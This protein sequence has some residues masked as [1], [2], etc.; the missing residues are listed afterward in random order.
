MGEPK[1]Y[2]DFYMVDGFIV[3]REIVVEDY[4][5]KPDL[6]R[7]VLVETEYEEVAKQSVVENQRLF[8]ND[9]IYYEPA[10]ILV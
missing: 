10:R 6:S 4:F 3:Y 9:A 5:G 7:E 8:P 1:R 2:G